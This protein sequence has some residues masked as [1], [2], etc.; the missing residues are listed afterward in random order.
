MTSKEYKIA[1]GELFYDAKSGEDIY[2]RA[3]KYR[4]RY[5]ADKKNNAGDGLVFLAGCVAAFF[6][7]YVNEDIC[8]FATDLLGDDW[9]LF[10]RDEAARANIRSS[11]LQ[12]GVEHYK[13]SY[14]P[15]EICREYARGTAGII[16]KNEQIFDK[17]MRRAADAGDAQCQYYVG[18]DLEKAGRL[19]KAAEWYEKS[20]KQGYVDAMGSLGEY[21]YNE[22]GN[23]PMAG[24]WFEQAANKGNEEARRILNDH[25]YWNS[26]RQMW[27]KK[28]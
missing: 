28:T 6:E 20:A 14:Y 25:F 18:C 23:Y 1:L 5:Y 7:G 11:I 2:R 24:Y 15:K 4:K 27:W 3:D 8:F 17:W 9:G 22:K 13:N 21:L 10:E 12:Y 19:R 16:K 26:Q